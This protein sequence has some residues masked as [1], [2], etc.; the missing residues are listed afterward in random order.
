ML[1]MRKCIFLK[2]IVVL[3]GLFFLAPAQ[4]HYLW[5]EKVDGQPRIYFGEYQEG[6]HEKS[7]GRL[8]TIAQPQVQALLIGKNPADI[9]VERK[10]DHLALIK[11]PAKARLIAQ[12]V[13]LKVK[14]LSKNKIGIVKPMYYARLAVGDVEDKSSLTLDI[15]PIGVGR[16]R[17]NFQGQPLVGETLVFY[18]PNQWMRE[19]KTDQNGEV[20]ITMPWQGSYVAEVV[21]LESAPGVYQGDTYDSVRHVGTLTVMHP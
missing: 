9:A 1:C 10:D 2:S 4:A 14:D 12:D 21:H 16:L 11:A 13:G 6:L 20:I 19:Y 7:G 18:A 8:D 17:V 3:I 15:Q 5:L